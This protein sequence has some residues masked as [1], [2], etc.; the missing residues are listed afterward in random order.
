AAAAPSANPAASPRGAV[1]GA[2]GH[3]GRWGVI[4]WILAVLLMV[5]FP[6]STQPAGSSSPIPH[7]PAAGQC[8]PIPGCAAPNPP[9]AVPYPCL[10]GRAWAWGNNV[11]GALGDGTAIDRYVPVPVQLPAG[12]TVTAISADQQSLALTSTGQ[13]LAWG[14][15]LSGELGDGTTT[16]R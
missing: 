3:R 9:P 8:T 2:Q 14:Y 11:S 4:A 13:V 1:S 5:A 12:T 7:R 16:D 6:T 10:A 15:N